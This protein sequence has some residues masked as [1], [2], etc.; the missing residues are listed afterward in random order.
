M[1]TWRDVIAIGK[2]FPGVEEGTWFRR[3]PDMDDKEA[4]IQGDPETF[5][6]TPH[7]DGSPFVLVRLEDGWR[8]RAPKK[9]IAA[10]DSDGG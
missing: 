6:T 3:V 8:T 10:F 5:F 7:C 9:L 1:A 4:L 2:R